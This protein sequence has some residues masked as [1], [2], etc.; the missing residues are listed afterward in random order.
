MPA[1]R[2]HV[3][4]QR[5]IW[6]VLL[7]LSHP[8]F[9]W[10]AQCASFGAALLAARNFTTPRAFREVRP[11]G[12]GNQQCAFP[13]RAGRMKQL[14]KKEQMKRMKVLCAVAA[15]F[16]AA[17]AFPGPGIFG[18]GTNTCSTNITHTNMMGT[19]VFLGPLSPYDVNGDGTISSNEFRDSQRFA[20]ATPVNELPR[21]VRW[22]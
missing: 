1:Q 16:A 21:E 17:S 9:G 6:R 20:R 19:N 15:M 18:S 4:C 10:V 7:L 14:K 13:G 11:H 8:S 12:N 2:S 5:T 3:I 22:Q